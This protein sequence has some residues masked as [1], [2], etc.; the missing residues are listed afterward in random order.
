MDENRWV[1]A[2]LG[3]MAELLE[4]QG[5]NPFRAGAYRRAADVVGRWARPLREILDARGRRGL[6]DIPGIGTGISASIAEM[7]ITGAWGQLRRLRGE[8]DARAHHESVPAA[9]ELPDAGT[10]LE[11]DREYREKARGGAL[12]LIAPKRF[13]PGGRAWLPVLHAKRGRWHFTALFSNT[14]RAH[15]LGRTH[16]WVVIY[17]YDDEHREGQCTVVTAT[18]GEHAGARVVRGHEPARLRTAA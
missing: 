3:E 16:D 7:L 12:R 15:E 10:L 9:G 18:R 2:Q 14:A 4:A 6:Q 8:T 5:A 11:I 1:A 17:F 13:N